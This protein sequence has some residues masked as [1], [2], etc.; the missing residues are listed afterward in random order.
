ME[1]TKRWVAMNWNKVFGLS[2]QGSMNSNFAQ[3]KSI[4]PFDKWVWLGQIFH[5]MK[6]NLMFEVFF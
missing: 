1:H 6:Q 4:L 3:G 2:K 5:I